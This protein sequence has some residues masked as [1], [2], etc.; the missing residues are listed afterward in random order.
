MIKE[1]IMKTKVRKLY[2]PIV[3]AYPMRMTFTGQPSSAA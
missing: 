3:K 2:D 1:A